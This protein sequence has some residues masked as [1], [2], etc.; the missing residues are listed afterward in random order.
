MCPCS[1]QAWHP[2]LGAVGHRCVSVDVHSVPFSILQFGNLHCIASTVC[3]DGLLV[4]NFKV[5]LCCE[6]TEGLLLSPACRAVALDLRDCVTFKGHSS[7]TW[8]PNSTISGPEDIVWTVAHEK[9]AEEAF[10]RRAA[11]ACALHAFRS[12]IHPFF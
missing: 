5:Y 11:R 12:C 10:L 2:A 8:Y 1:A 3:H 7:P 6:I 9:M 4:Y